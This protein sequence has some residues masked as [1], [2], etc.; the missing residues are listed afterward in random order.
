MVLAHSS[1][2]PFFLPPED[3]YPVLLRPNSTPQ[4]GT[5][6]RP[7][8]AAAAAA[9]GDGAQ[10][11]RTGPRQTNEASA[12]KVFT[13]TT[14]LV[15]AVCQPSP[16]PVAAATRSAAPSRFPKFQESALDFHLVLHRGKVT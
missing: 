8:Q 5:R 4:W 3:P 6:P 9:G 1:H 11:A 16:S 14:S 7:C 15:A 13:F 2:H 12:Q 10:E